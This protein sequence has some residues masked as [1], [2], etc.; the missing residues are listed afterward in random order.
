MNRLE[1]QTV[2]LLNS[3]VEIDSTN[4]ELVPGGAGEGEIADFVSGWL[5]ERG[6]TCQRL[7]SRPG[8]PSIV[9]THAG[10]GG[11]SS[12]M[13]N[14]HL[15]AVSLASY[16]ADGLAPVVRNGS[17]HGRGTYDMKSGV[18]AMMV[19]AADVASREHAGDIVLALVADEEYE[20]YGTEEVVARG[21]T[22]D[23]AIVAEPTGL[24]IVTAHRGFVWCE[25]TVHGRAAHGSR[26]DLGVD[27]IAKAGH[28]LAALDRHDRE[29]VQ[30]APHP[31]LGTGNIHAAT[32]TGGEELSSYPAL[33]RIG[34]ERRTLP[35]ESAETVTAELRALIDTISQGDADFSAEVA[36]TFERQPFHVPD[37][38]P[39]VQSLQRNFEEVTGE[40]ARM[41]GE[42]FWTDCALLTAAGIPSV[43]FGVDGGGAH[44]AD[45][46]V[47]L[48]SL[49]TATEVLR[50][51]IADAVGAARE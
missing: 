13:L 18:A 43:L 3:L 48:D 5:A 11:G 10:S 49:H 29:L 39:I 21:F 26:R 2:T 30:R 4:P 8:R 15:D 22:A 31:L 25:V 37:D 23:A 12:I 27:A 51:T 36:V 14:G 33:C 7:E 47:T 44:A 24:D 28:F 41:R 6:F 19:A 9:A 17:L 34:I 40:A 42:L 35:G 45:E 20:S 50:R 1:S 38:A 46:W 16:D 32:I